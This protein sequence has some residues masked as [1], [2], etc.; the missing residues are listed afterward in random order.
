MNSV[1]AQ[2][3]EIKHWL[4]AGV[5]DGSVVGAAAPPKP[6]PSPP[7]MS[8]RRHRVDSSLTDLSQPK[9]TGFIATVLISPPATATILPTH[10][11]LI[12]TRRAPK[13]T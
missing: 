6:A 11:P 10:V 5:N 3:P 4:I 7:T 9:L 2:H 8:P 12:K 1:M 13:T